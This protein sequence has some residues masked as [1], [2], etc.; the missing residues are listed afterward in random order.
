MR[1]FHE[2]KGRFGYRRIRLLMQEEGMFLSRK[3]VARLLRAAGCVSKVRQKRFNSFR[4]VQGKLAENLVKRDF[5]RAQPNRLW[6]TDITQ[7][8]VNGQNLYL[9]AILDTCTRQIVAFRTGVSPQVSLVTRMLDEAVAKEVFVKGLIM[10]SD[11]GFQYFNEQFTVR[12]A[13]AG[14]VQSMSRRGNCLD[15]S[16]MECFFGHLKQEIFVGRQFQSVDQLTVEIDQYMRWYNYQRIQER[17]G[18]MSPVE[19]RRSIEWRFE[20]VAC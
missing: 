12:L 15:N 13:A 7:F 2:N 4:G 9:S 19:F 6:L 11:Q 16:P 20:P 17:L 1:L 14:I 5:S 10:H 18:A 8:Q 3:T